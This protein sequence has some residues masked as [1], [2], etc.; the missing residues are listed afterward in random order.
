MNNGLRNFS[1]NYQNY[2]NE[3]TTFANVSI[4]PHL[5]T[6]HVDKPLL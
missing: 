4:H 2:V 5:H 6:T 3:F 1:Y